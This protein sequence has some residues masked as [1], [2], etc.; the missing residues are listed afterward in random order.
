MRTVPGPIATALAGGATMPVLALELL[1]DSGAV[2]LWTGVGNITIN[3]DTYLGVQ[4]IITMSPA[5]EN[6]EL[7]S[8]NLTVTLS[9]LDAGIIAVALSE[10]YQ[11]RTARLW[12]TVQGEPQAV[13]IY[14]G[15]MN[16]L[17]PFDD[18]KNATLT[19]EIESRLLDLE[20]VNGWRYTQET[21]ESLYPGDTFFRYVS[22]LA[23][24]DID[25]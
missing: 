1:F 8:S 4:D 22:K 18:G 13:E 24:K 19:L 20:K 25:W 3:G 10:P 11:G 23:D 14:S 5:A 15:Y 6:S 21:M 2:R 12:F 9:G 17:S 7:E 16:Q